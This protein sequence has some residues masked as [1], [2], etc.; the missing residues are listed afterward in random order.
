MRFGVAEAQAEGVL[1]L[2]GL[3]RSVGLARTE[4]VVVLKL[5]GLWGFEG[6][7]RSLELAEL[8][9][10]QRPRLLRSTHV[11]FLP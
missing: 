1:K 7:W 9:R 4:E 2:G 8:Q 6:F 10:R 5:E 11:A 3:W